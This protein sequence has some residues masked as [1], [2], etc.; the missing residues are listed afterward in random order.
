MVE[1][2][3]ELWFYEDQTENMKLGC[4]ISNILYNEK[5]EYQSI[6]VVDTYEYGR[7][8]ALDGAVQLTEADEFC[9]H[10]MLAHVVISA[11]PLPQNIMI[12]GG[13]DGGVVR[14]ALK[15]STVKKI[16]LVDIDKKVIEI[17]KKYFPQVSCRLNDPRVE[18]KAEDALVFVKNI[19][20]QYDIIIIDST[21]PVDIAKGLFESPFYQDVYNALKEDGMC[22]AQTESPFCMK[23]VFVNA[24]KEMKKVF[25]N[26][27]VY[28]GVV[29][30]YPSGFWTYTIGS[31][32]YDPT[33]IRHDISNLKTKYYTPQIH[34]ACFA[35]P[36]F[37]EEVLQQKDKGDR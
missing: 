32:K 12:V 15:H 13:G 26:V 24:N 10:E 30:T 29:P 8:L 20:D 28:W 21:D 35:L 9:Y 7:L 23:D 3:N 5:S 4:R 1:R 14:E 36:P 6:V 37:M 2:G 22:V 27:Y 18:I 11:H 19:K 33:Q 31:K 16:T 17:S 34:K 25:P